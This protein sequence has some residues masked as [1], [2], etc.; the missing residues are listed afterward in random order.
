MTNAPEREASVAV[1]ET[2]NSK[3]GE[4]LSAAEVRLGKEP[5]FS[6]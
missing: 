4:H 1:R 5:T 3:A 6:D 2:D